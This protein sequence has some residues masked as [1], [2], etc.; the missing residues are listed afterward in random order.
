MGLVRALAVDLEAPDHLPAC[1][2][3]GDL[4]HP[5]ASQCESCGARL[6][7]RGAHV[8]QPAPVRPRCTCGGNGICIV[9]ALDAYDDGRQ[10]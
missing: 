5:S 4:C 7:P 6:L 10:P 9:C 3:C 1:T 2:D 8:A